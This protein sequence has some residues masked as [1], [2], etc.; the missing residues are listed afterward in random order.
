MTQIKHSP[1]EYRSKANAL[2]TE[3]FFMCNEEQWKIDLNLMLGQ[4]FA[5]RE[6]LHDAPPE[7]CNPAVELAKEI[8]RLERMA[9][10]PTYPESYRWPDR[11]PNPESFAGRLLNNADPKQTC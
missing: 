3:L 2:R 10:D 1:E 5:L 6:D 7:K 9:D 8:Y 11:T 4:N